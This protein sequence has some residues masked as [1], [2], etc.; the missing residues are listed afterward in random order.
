MPSQDISHQDE[1]AT[2]N[3]LHARGAI[4]LKTV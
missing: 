4:P 3:G 1:K 2:E